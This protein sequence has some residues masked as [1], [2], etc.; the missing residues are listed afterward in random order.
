VLPLPVGIPV[1]PKSVPHQR[2]Y[3]AYRGAEPFVFISYSHDDEVVVGN[4][5]AALAARGI[6]INYDEGIHP[7]R[8]W[9]DELAHAIEHCALFVMLVTPRSVASPHCERELSFALENE[10]PILPVLL[11]DTQI[12]AGIRLQIGNRQAI[13]RSQFD[14]A[15]FQTRLA[16]AIFGYVDPATDQTPPTALPTSG[17]ATSGHRLRTRSRQVAVGVSII[18]ALLVLAYAGF[19]RWNA[20]Q[21]EHQRRTQAVAE[22]SRLINQDRYGAAFTLARPLI[23]PSGADADP[24]I[25][26]QWKQIVVPMTPLVSEDGATVFFKPYDDI[27]GDWILA[28]NS[29]F[30]KPIDAPRGVLRLKIEKPGFRTGYFAVANPGP[31][32]QSADELARITLEI[33]AT[34]APLKLAAA[35]A[36]S[37]DM[38]LVP[39]SNVPV[40]ISGWTLDYR[41]SNPHDIPDFAIG[42]TEVT[43]REFKEFVDAHGYDNATLWQ[44]LKFVDDGHEL[45]APEAHAR[46]VDRTGRPGPAGWELGTFPTGTAELPVGGISWYEAVAYARF[47]GQSLPTV[48][49][50]LRAAL[51]PYEGLYPTG[52]AVA[53]SS[54]FSA[55]GPVAA[56]DGVGLGP[57]GT[58]NAAGNVREWVWNFAGDKALVLGG[59]WPD[60]PATYSYAYTARPM[61]RSPEYGLRL[62]QLLGD[63]PLPREL[64][65]PIQL[66]LDSDYVRRSPVS[67]DAF[68]AMR[69]QY[70]ATHRTPKSVT[71]NEVTHSDTWVADEVVLDF[72]GGDAFT[73]YVVRPRGH[74]R[75]L[76][77]IVY[78]PSGDAIESAQP[79]RRA[80]AQ[81]PVAEFIASS[82]RALVMPIWALSYQRFEP[83]PV[84]VDALQDRFRRAPLAWYQDLVT[85]LDYLQTR[86][87]IDADRIGFIGF[88]FG[89][90]FIAPPLLAVEGRTK[91]AVLVSGGIWTGFP[92]HP[93]LDAVNYVPHITIPILM[94]NGRY[95]SLFPHEVSQKRFFDLLGTPPADKRQVMY[96]KAHMVLLE[97]QARR[98]ASD[99]FDR[100]L[101]PVR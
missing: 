92:I 21:T 47:R 64:L 43:N 80:L 85:T 30:V 8:S 76:Q 40:F 29:P 28:G 41:G 9:H 45:S 53:N 100:Y 50:W 96:D 82:G 65:E 13:I 61:D 66:T 44:G 79:N 7:G 55:D 74:A 68:A 16:S 78:G 14:D 56:K 58:L 63:A 72:A 20:A 38:M 36:L 69:F 67:D 93:M 33:P 49:H 89:S 101:G 3:P 35:G 84:A 24:A 48:H 59:A 18:A 54:R 52:P 22:V 32:L 19:T 73:L 99:W 4:L 83:M 97:N 26:A 57:W 51:G 94:I 39:H 62:M 6:R 88:S 1:L 86:D 91:A 17:D 34:P 15:D 5:I 81:L 12:P 31:S 2:R 37:D 42:R 77:A 11:E 95:D 27:D 90:S 60:Y 23:E 75:P 46:F 10:R 70:T 87:D 98:E 25:L 71:V